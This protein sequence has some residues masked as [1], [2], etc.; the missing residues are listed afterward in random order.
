MINVFDE[1]LDQNSE[2]YLRGIQRG[3]SVR[4]TGIVGLEFEAGH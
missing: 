2:E 3:A 4:K 1:Y